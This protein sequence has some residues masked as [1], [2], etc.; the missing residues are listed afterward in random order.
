VVEVRPEHDLEV[1]PVGQGEAHVGHP[2]L[3]ELPGALLRRDQL[4]RQQ[5]VALGGERGEQPR[6]VPE[7]VGGCGMGDPG[8]SRQVPQADAGRPDV[9]DGGVRGGQQRPAQVTV[10]VGAGARHGVS[11]PSI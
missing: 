9:G 6:L 1:R 11:L 4:L 8:A 7:V 10:V 2:H 5:V 3:Q